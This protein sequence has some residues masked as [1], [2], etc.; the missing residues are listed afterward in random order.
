MPLSVKII[1]GSIGAGKTSVLH[2]LKSCTMYNSSIYMFEEDV[3][4]W[5][6]YLQ[7]FYADPEAYVFF[8]QKEVEAHFLRLTRILEKM[9]EESGALDIVAIV[10][11]SPLD[12]AHVFLPL[13]KDKMT[14]AEYENL[15]FTM[16]KFTQ[17]PVW[18]EAQYFFVTCPVNECMRRIAQRN[19]GGE[20]CIDKTYLEQVH[21][22]YS[23]MI[24]R[25]VINTPI[26]VLENFGYEN[27]L[28]TSAMQIVDSI[29]AP[30]TKKAN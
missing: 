9:D 29:V 17:R 26:T 12:V 8:F 30:Q 28:L 21:N 25:G 6:F 24:T 16:V 19:R 13:N 2:A 1:S 18:K 23:A 22:F 7:K 11:R 14:Q 4:E 3:S 20:E 10:E 27:A 15:M 5:Q